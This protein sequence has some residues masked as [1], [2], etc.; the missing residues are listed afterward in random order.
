MYKYI[1]LWRTDMQ[2]KQI[3]IIIEACCRQSAPFIVK[4]INY[5]TSNLLHYKR[6]KAVN[7]TKLKPNLLLH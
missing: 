7:V 6:N 2:C 1:L 4:H 3:N 5:K